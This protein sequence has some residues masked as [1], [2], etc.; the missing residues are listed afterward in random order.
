MGKDR[1][2]G[3]IVVYVR[4]KRIFHAGPV[5]HLIG[6]EAL[7]PIQYGLPGDINIHRSVLFLCL[8]NRQPRKGGGS[9]VCS[10]MVYK[11]FY[12]IV[13]LTKGEGF[14]PEGRK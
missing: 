7:L 9:L 12:D 3:F 4:G 10:E 2:G 8:K 13:M 14:L 1:M 11:V 5:E 6:K